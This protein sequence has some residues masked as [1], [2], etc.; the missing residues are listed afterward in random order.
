MIGP[1]GAVI[2]TKTVVECENV[3]LI[4]SVQLP[5]AAD[6]TLSAP[7]ATALYDSIPAQPLTVNVPPKPGS[8]TLTVWVAPLERE[9]LAGETDNGPIG[10][11]VPIEN[12]SETDTGV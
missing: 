8:F 11:P 5:D 2:L 6:V 3:S 4:V 10:P 9:R 1:L 7:F 12:G